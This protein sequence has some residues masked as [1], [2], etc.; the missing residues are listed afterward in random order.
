MLSP[1]RW[2]I[3]LTIIYHNQ[4]KMSILVRLLIHHPIHHLLSILCRKN[5]TQNTSQ[6]TNSLYKDAEIEQKVKSIVTSPAMRRQ[7]QV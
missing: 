2:S 3:L 5:N 6:P 7:M 1:H 4:H